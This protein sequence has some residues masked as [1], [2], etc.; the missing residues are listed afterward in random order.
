MMKV[1]FIK[2]FIERKLFLTDLED[3]E[4]PSTHCAEAFGEDN[5]QCLLCTQYGDGDPQVSIY[6]SIGNDLS[7]QV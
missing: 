1:H 4:S 2:I 7:Q 5:R 3:G 6:L